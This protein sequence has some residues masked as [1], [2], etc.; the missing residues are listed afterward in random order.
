MNTGN[1][2]RV[3]PRTPRALPQ[4]Q[5]KKTKKTPACVLVLVYAL[6]EPASDLVAAR[7][8]FRAPDL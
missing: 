6:M 4:K 2:K 7:Q 5:T 1:S 3:K 8:A